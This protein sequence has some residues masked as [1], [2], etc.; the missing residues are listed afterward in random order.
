M[1]VHKNGTRYFTQE[2]YDF[3][4]YQASTL[5]YVRAAGY[6]LVQEQ[7]W[8]HLREHDS[9]VFGQNGQWY[10]NSRGLRG[11]AIEFLT[12]VEHKTLV[13]AVLTLNGELTSQLNQTTQRE[14]PFQKK[15]PQA[16]ND[17]F[18]L[19]EPAKQYRR[20]FAY[21]CETRKLDY[22]IVKEL[23]EQKRIYEGINR[24]IISGEHREIH[25]AVFVSF[26]EQGAPRAAFQRGLMTQGKPYKGDVPGSDKERFGWIMPGAKDVTSL[27]VFE[28]AIDAI[29]HAT[30]QKTAG[31]DYRREHRIAVGGNTNLQ[32]VLNYLQTHPE[33]R[34]IN[35]CFDA[36]AA[37]DRGTNLLHGLLKTHEYDNAHGYTILRQKPADGKDFNEMLQL[38]LQQLEGDRTCDRS[39]FNPMEESEVAP[40]Q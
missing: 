38:R 15:E 37:G 18:D 1:P 2:Q 8:Y 13:D 34:T 12:Q 11:G 19:P 35:I 20:L 4:R 7:K 40:E 33:I 36:D 26:D 22:D 16:K 32:P 23:V 29:S 30:M 31:K 21:L 28:A 39:F 10:W 24:P 17:S 3:A 25:N 27:S 9:M 6:D 5:E 14:R